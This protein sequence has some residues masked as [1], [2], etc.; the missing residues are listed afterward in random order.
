MSDLYTSANQ[1]SLCA[2]L[3]SSMRAL[4]SSQN[5]IHVNKGHCSILMVLFPLFIPLCP[6]GALVVVDVR[7]CFTSWR[8]NLCKTIAVT[9]FHKIC[10]SGDVKVME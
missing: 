2:V 1:R 6:D 9:G 3:T 10:L 4:G 7:G 8:E 5:T